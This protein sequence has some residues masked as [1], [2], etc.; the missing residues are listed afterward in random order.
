MIIIALRSRSNLDRGRLFVRSMIV[1]AD[2]IRSC[3]T[4]FRFFAIDAARKRYVWVLLKRGHKCLANLFRARTNI[5]I[6][7]LCSA[8][9]T[10]LITREMRKVRTAVFRILL[11]ILYIVFLLFLYFIFY[12][13]VDN[14]W[15]TIWNYTIDNHLFNRK[16]IIS[17]S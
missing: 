9:A 13:N 12:R 2:G 11:F 14:L 15:R 17:Q 8:N 3:R 7:R 5:D 1:P 10:N 16:E 6:N 4:L